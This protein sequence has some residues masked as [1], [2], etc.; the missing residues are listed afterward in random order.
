M[1]ESIGRFT[2]EPLRAEIG[3]KG[4]HTSRQTPQETAEA[5]WEPW[6]SDYS[7]HEGIQDPMPIVLS[8]LSIINGLHGAAAQKVAESSLER[9][10]GAV[11]ENQISYHTQQEQ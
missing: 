5:F 7:F 3:K 2:S 8:R 1:P 6:V 11:Q 4:G 10:I 9:V